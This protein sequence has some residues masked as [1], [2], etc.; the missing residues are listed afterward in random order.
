MYNMSS[1]ELF[2]SMSTHGI[3][4]FIEGWC[5][6]AITKRTPCQCLSPQMQYHAFT[7]SARDRV[8]PYHLKEC[9]VRS[10]RR[11][12]ANPDPVLQAHLYCAGTRIGDSHL[13]SRSA[14]RSFII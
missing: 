13:N 11:L 3:R 4:E 1:K 5:L 14:Q 10:L 6:E 2:L 9:Y 12:G 7:S 8:I